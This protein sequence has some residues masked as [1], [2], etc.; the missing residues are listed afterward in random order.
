VLEVISFVLKCIVDFVSM[1]FTVD[2]GHSISLGTLMC[3][4]FIFLPIASYV[5]NFLKGEFIGEFDDF[6]DTRANKGNNENKK[7]NK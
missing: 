1:L 4:C 5:I 7:E 2:I 3:V 6:F